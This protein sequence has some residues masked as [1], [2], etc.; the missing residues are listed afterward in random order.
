MGLLTIIIADKCIFKSLRHGLWT[1]FFRKKTPK[2]S[3]HKSVRRI[4]AQKHLG[5][6]MGS[7]KND[8]STLNMT[9]WLSTTKKIPHFSN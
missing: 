2:K 7:R 5:L 9:V 4:M 8:N 3:L 6:I 1:R